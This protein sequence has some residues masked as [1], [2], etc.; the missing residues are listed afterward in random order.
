MITQT[1]IRSLST[2][3]VCMCA[4]VCMCLCACVRVCTCHCL[5]YAASA[6]SLNRFYMA[7]L[8]LGWSTAVSP[9]DTCIW[10]ASICGPEVKF[11]IMKII[12]EAGQ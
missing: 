10:G 6:D 8:A 11:H 7:E 9:A 3:T 2:V 4:C 5:I 1:P 12:I